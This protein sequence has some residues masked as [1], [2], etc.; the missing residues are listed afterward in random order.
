MVW[1]IWI[2]FPTEFT[3]FTR[4][5]ISILNFTDCLHA[6]EV[7][8]HA[9][10]ST[11]FITETPERTQNSTAK[12]V[13]LGSSW[14]TQTRSWYL[15]FFLLI[16]ELPCHRFK[17]QHSMRAFNPFITLFIIVIV[18]L[19]IPNVEGFCDLAPVLIHPGSSTRTCFNELRLR[20][21]NLFG[22]M[23]KKSSGSKSRTSPHVRIFAVAPTPIDES[24]KT[25]FVGLKRVPIKESLRE[26]GTDTIISD[27][28]WLLTAVALAHYA[29]VPSA[30][31][32]GWT[33]FSNS[34]KLGSILSALPSSD[35]GIVN[36]DPTFSVFLILIGHLLN[37]G[38]FLP[39]VMHEYEYWQIAEMKDPVSE[40]TGIVPTSSHNNQRLYTST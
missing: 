12:V 15:H 26:Y 18:T 40:Q 36:A 10:L 14:R 20:G 9:G 11:N 32:L 1:D 19:E 27:Q 7:M 29:L 28:P 4:D 37:M 34:A 6:Q 2:F 23:T 39:F 5:A 13:R 17:S 24:P 25:S 16:I 3:T 8:L 31:V 21:R 33:L 35:G 30:F 22:R 38:S